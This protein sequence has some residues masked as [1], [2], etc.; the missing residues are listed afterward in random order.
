LA[1]LGRRWSRLVQIS[2]NPDVDPVRA[3]VPAGGGIMIRPDGHI[4][5]R[6][7]S[8]QAEAF[9]ALDRHFSSDLIPAPLV[10]PVGGA[11]ASTG[12]GSDARTRPVGGTH[13][14]QGR[15]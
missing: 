9:T 10:D 14:N 1:R 5:F 15:G 11:I 3:G 13:E 6:F 12:E 4:R 2:H 7:P 8:T